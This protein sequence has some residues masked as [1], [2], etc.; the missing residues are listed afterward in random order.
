MNTKKL[1]IL[2]AS[3]FYAPF[4]GGAERQ[5]QLLGQELTL[6]GHEI[7][8][9]TVRQGD[10]PAQTNENGVELHRLGAFF[11]LVDWFSSN[12]QRRFHPPFADLLLV[13]NLRRLILRFQPDVIHAN[14]WIAYSC[15]AALL[16][17]K[18]PLL[19]SVR[20]Y[21]Y[22]C[23]TRTL[24]KDNAV[25]N[26]PALGKC[27]SCAGQTYRSKPKG[28][29]AVMGVMGGQWLLRRKMS[30]THSVSTFVQQIVRRDLL[31]RSTTIGIVAGS[32]P[33][34]TIPDI[35][36]PSFLAPVA[37]D[38]EN[39]EL[40]ENQ[41]AIINQYLEKLPTE[42]FLLFV[43]S[44][45]PHKGLNV[46]V[47]AY[48]RLEAPPP[49]VLVGSHWHDTPKEFPKGVTVLTNVPHPAVM[50]I[51]E[52]ALLGVLPSVWADPLPG[53]VREGMLKGKAI[54]ATA[55]GGNLDMIENEVTGVLVTPGD[56]QCLQLAIERLLA[57]AQLRDSLGIAAQERVKAFSA[58]AVVPQFENLYTEMARGN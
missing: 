15:A 20:D 14:G 58:L 8:I 39:P 45:Q 2:I 26:G 4:I 41:R 56:A 9:A 48:R 54:I 49:L 53:V 36:I 23:A 1:R 10:L 25:C 51:W 24:L 17:L 21:G 3:D 37:P 35:V 33:T 57:S 28:W 40:V 18:I 19:V 31:K 12:S 55:T 50:A 47:E 6:Q 44:L 46:L 11:T 16:G 52:K 27:L 32:Q 29:A 42:P 13:W 34:L 22:S 38:T 5:V 30:A 7:C 43:G